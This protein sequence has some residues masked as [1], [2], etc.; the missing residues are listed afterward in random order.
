MDRQGMTEYCF[1][2]KVFLFFYFKGLQGYIDLL[3]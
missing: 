2:L 1:E 3:N